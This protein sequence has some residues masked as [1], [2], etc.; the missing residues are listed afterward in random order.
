MMA[1]S[2][3]FPQFT[4]AHQS[5]ENH[6]Q[7]DYI[8]FE[9]AVLRSSQT[10]FSQMYF[11]SLLSSYAHINS[12]THSRSLQPPTQNKFRLLAEISANL[13]STFCLKEKQINKKTELCL[14]LFIKK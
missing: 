13:S 9:A 3:I 12:H 14:C 7:R 5:K 1:I 11:Y 10:Y 4:E 8:H 2:E 6:Q